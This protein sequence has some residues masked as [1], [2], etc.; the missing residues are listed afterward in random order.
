MNTDVCATEI[1][2]VVTVATHEGTHHADDVGGVVTLKKVI[3]ASG[4]KCK[5]IRTRD[6]ALIEQADFVVD[7]GLIYEPAAGRFDHHQSIGA[8]YRESEAAEPYA[9][10]GLVWRE[11]GAAL[12]EDNKRVANMVDRHLVRH[13]DLV[14]CGY[15]S[16]A[17]YSVSSAISAFN[18]CWDEDGDG[19]KS[20]EAACDFFGSLLD[21]EI[22]RARA[23]AATPKMVRKFHKNS[24]KSGTPDGILVLDNFVPWKA[25]VSTEFPEIEFVVFPDRVGNWVVSTVPQSPGSRM[26]KKQLPRTWG[27]LNNQQLDQEVGIPGCVFCHNNLF[28]ALHLCKEGAITMADVARRVH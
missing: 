12:C 5:I 18:L 13:I 16:G 2:E 26:P 19:M 4:S 23:L 24:K 6:P 9:A 28:M 8:G 10:F 17:G 14:D 21:R 20:F 22:A 15:T 11:F 3:E 27:G 25:I 7:V 1:P